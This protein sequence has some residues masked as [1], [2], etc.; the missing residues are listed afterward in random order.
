MGRKLGSACA[1]ALGT[2]QSKRGGKE[3][4]QWIPKL[5]LVWGIDSCSS[6]SIFAAFPLADFDQLV[7]RFPALPRSGCQ[8]CRNANRSPAQRCGPPGARRQL[9]VRPTGK[10]APALTGCRRPPS[11]AEALEADAEPRARASPGAPG[12]SSSSHSRLHLATWPPVRV[13]LSES[14]TLLANSGFLLW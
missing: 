3:R 8:G 1:V 2:S 14:G 10:A 12:R 6:K 11:T 9:P 7:V 4:A 13:A 5:N